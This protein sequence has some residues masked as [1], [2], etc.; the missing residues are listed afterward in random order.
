MGGRDSKDT[1]ALVTVT[2]NMGIEIKPND[3][4]IYLYT[5]SQKKLEIINMNGHAVRF[6]IQ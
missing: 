5:M 1:N 4:F 6:Y 3:A 2:G